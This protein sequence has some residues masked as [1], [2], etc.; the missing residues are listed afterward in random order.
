MTS[1]ISIWANFID[2]QEWV[3][4]K[5]MPETPHWYIIKNRLKNEDVT[6]FEGFVHFI[7]EKGLK[8][9]FQNKI[10]SYYNFGDY[11]YWTMGEPIEKTVVLNR[12]KKVVVSVLEKYKNIPDNLKPDDDHPYRMPVLT[13]EEED[14]MAKEVLEK[15]WN[16]DGSLK[17]PLKNKTEAKAPI[18]TVNQTY[19]QFIE[20]FRA[21][22]NFYFINTFEEAAIRHSQNGYFIRFKGEQEFTTQQTNHLICDAFMEFKEITEKEYNEY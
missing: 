16:K 18:I 1:D 17:K 3:Y 20:R 12:A 5:T 13:E 4:A 10:Y 14:Q 15:F 8:R 2:N 6:I 7:R 19:E 9:V 22:P 11:D 21:L